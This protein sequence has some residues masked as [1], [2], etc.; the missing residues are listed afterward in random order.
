ME[1]CGL[2]I[3]FR[4]CDRLHS[5]WYLHKIGDWIMEKIDIVLLI[6]GFCGIL[7]SGLFQPYLENWIILT[8]SLFFLGFSFT[9]FGA[10]FV[11]IIWGFLNDRKR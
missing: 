2:F 8:F 4:I 10:G 1:T 9:A 7:I 11:F 3:L 5:D 6:L